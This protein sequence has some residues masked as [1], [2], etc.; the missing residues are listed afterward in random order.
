MRLFLSKTVSSTK[1][2]PKITRLSFVREGSEKWKTIQDQGFRQ[3]ST[4][5]PVPFLVLSTRKGTGSLVRKSFYALATKHLG[6][7]MLNGRLVGR[8]VS[9]QLS[10]KFQK[11]SNKHHETNSVLV[12]WHLPDGISTH[13]VDS[14]DIKMK[15]T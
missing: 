13:R 8:L 9:T 7:G 6:I 11:L 1:T 14:E 5:N 12:F 15:M 2:N 10:K 3:L 4:K